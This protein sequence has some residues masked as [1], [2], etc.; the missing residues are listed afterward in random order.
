MNQ[1]SVSFINL[2]KAQAHARAH[3]HTRACT[4][5]SS[6]P[7][8]QRHREARW[9]ISNVHW[10]KRTPGPGPVSPLQET[11]TR[12]TPWTRLPSAG[13]T[14]LVSVRC[15]SRVR[16]GSVQVSA[17]TCYR[18]IIDPSRASSGLQ[19]SFEVLALP[20]PPPP[21]LHLSR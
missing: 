9:W 12:L 13:V 15:S 6:A 14:S 2:L 1:S 10:E 21:P 20:L 18:L 17:V 8:E 4:P 11:R 16:T 7:P 19:S 3:T 5:L